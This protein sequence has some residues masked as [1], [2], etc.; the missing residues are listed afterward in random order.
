M[1]QNI[2]HFK[3]NQLKHRAIA[4][5]SLQKQMHQISSDHTLDDGEA[6][7]SLDSRFSVDSVAVFVTCVFIRM[8]CLY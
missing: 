4:V 8:P 1:D 5:S 2:V 3:D 7:S 6:G